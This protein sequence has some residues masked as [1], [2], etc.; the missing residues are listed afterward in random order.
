MVTSFLDDLAAGDDWTII[1]DIT[2]V[3]D[4]IAITAGTMLVKATPDTPDN[5]A[6]LTKNITT[7]YVPETGGITAAPPI[8]TLRYEFTETET[9]TLQTGKTYYYKIRYTTDQTPAQTK[10]AERGTLI[11]K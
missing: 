5:G 10:T 7:N 2:A 1:R 9:N 8:Y 11:V 3:P 4:G 6:V